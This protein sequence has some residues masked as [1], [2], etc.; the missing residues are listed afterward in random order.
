MNNKSRGDHDSIGDKNAKIAYSILN[1][2]TSNNKL[3]LVDNHVKQLVY[4]I[5]DRM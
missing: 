3:L 4:E 2:L 5:L 1:E